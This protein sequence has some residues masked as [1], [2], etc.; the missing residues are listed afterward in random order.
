MVR[1]LA[2]AALTGVVLLLLAAMASFLSICWQINR[3]GAHDQAQ[4]ADAIIVLGAR[5]RADGRPGP[6]LR[7][8]T[9]HGVRL[10]QQGLAPL[11]VCT[12]GYHNDRLSAASVACDLAVSKGVPRD[13]VLLAD[14]SMT[15]GEDAISTRHLASKHGLQTAILVSHPLHLARAQV[16][17][18]GQGIAVYPSPTSTDLRAIP[19]PT[20]AWLTTREAI[21]IL[22]IGLEEVGVPYEWTIALSRWIYG[23]PATPLAGAR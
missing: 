17:F 3:T 7:S 15:T 1:R 22:W 9:L 5:V 8:R 23:L 19:W 4:P 16:L 10:H 14:G 20:R 12:G 2:R 18:E 21:G 13:Q 6:D 11:L